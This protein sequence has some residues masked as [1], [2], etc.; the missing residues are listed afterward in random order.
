[1][2]HEVIRL[3]VEMKTEVEA[4]NWA[5]WHL[6]VSAVWSEQCIKIKLLPRKTSR[7]S[8]WNNTFFVNSNLRSFLLIMSI[9]KSNWVAM[10]NQIRQTSRNTCTPHCVLKHMILYTEDHCENLATTQTVKTQLIQVNCCTYNCLRSI[11]DSQL[12]FSPL[13]SLRIKSNLILNWYYFP[14]Q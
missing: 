1:M 3:P 4:S 8:Q 2:W 6:P 7:E 10:S 13:K 5:Q 9:K 11:I 12:L 14:K